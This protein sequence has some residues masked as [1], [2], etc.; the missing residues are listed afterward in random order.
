MLST[1]MQRMDVSRTHLDTTRKPFMP[2]IG[3]SDDL[4]VADAQERLRNLTRAWMD[5]LL[6]ATGGLPAP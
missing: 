1:A 4:A 2:D 5:A 3:A 6:T